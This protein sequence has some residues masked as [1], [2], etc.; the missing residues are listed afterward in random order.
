[1]AYTEAT[2][3]ALK[4]AF[5]AFADVDDEAVEFWLVR[6]KRMVDQSWTEGDYTFAQMLATCHL[7]TL[8][9]LGKGAESETAANGTGDFKVIRSASLTLERF[10][11]DKAS[12]QGE[13][14]STSYGR[15]FAALARLNVGGPRV[16]ATG[17]LPGCY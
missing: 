2:V 9:G 16:M 12:A 7:M 11:R 14:G 3:E 1:M 6:G 15:Q 13:I 17:T 8:N 4:A 5:P 10:D